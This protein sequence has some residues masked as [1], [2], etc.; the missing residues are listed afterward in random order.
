MGIA[1]TSSSVQ[2]NGDEKPLTS[3][4]ANLRPTRLAGY[5][6]YLAWILS[7]FYNT[8]LLI[9]ASD[10]RYRYRYFLPLSLFLIGGAGGKMPFLFPLLC[11]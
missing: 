11:S 1:Q 5:A 6:L 7:T 4:L 9:S 2:V 10:I 8:F 3:L